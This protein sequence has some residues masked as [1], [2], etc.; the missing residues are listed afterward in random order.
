MQGSLIRI[1]DIVHTAAF[2]DRLT[3]RLSRPGRC[4]VD[5]MTVAGEHWLAEHCHD[6]GMNQLLHRGH[7]GFVV[8]VGF[9]ELQHREFG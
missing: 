2:Q 4:D 3:E 7:H 9:V 8:G 1:V 5:L 6:G